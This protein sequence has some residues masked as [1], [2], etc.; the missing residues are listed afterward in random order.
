MIITYPDAITHKAII[1]TFCEYLNSALAT[2]DFVCP[3]LVVSPGRELFIIAEPHEIDNLN[4]E[5]IF[6]KFGEF[7]NSLKSKIEKNMAF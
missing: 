2:G 1:K 7:S 5:A 3:R 4:N 6:K